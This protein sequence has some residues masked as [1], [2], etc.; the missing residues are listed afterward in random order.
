MNVRGGNGMRKAQ[1]QKPS[2]PDA[3]RGID[4]PASIFASPLNFINATRE[5]IPGI[6]VRQAIQAFGHRELFV[7]IL[8]VQPTNL[9]RTY[10]RKRLNKTDSEAVLDLLRV[11]REA[12]Q[13]FESREIGE[14]WLSS[15]L[16]VLGS[17]RP[18]DI[19][20]TFQGRRLVR[21]ILQKVSHGDFS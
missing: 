6:V 11:F 1:P 2:Q 19:C 14:E 15:S 4:I 16:P 21:D 8:G 18:V 17:N 13:V 20:S 10:R 7:D 3:L 9:S 5:G 12:S